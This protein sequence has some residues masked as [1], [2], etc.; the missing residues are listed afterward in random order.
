MFIHELIRY[1]IPSS[2]PIT[3]LDLCAAPGGKSLLLNSTIHH[4]SIC[5]SNE[6][7][8]SRLAILRENLGKWGALN[9]LSIGENPRNIPFNEQFNLILVDAP[10][11]GE[12]LFRK[13]PSFREEWC[14]SH[15]LTC[16]MRQKEILLEAIRL[17]KPNGFLIYSTCTYA[18]EENEQILD[19]LV[20][21][22]KL[23]NL[24]IPIDPAWQIH[25]TNS[26]GGVGYQFLPH[27]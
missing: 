9:Q 3:A 12:G 21:E 26:S 19:W 4:E 11:S 2:Q 10:C 7:T 23:S 18:P 14:A 27:N 17:L 20:S 22:Q 1:A 16:S 24:K 15:A 5:I 25:L 8:P 6:I 13:H